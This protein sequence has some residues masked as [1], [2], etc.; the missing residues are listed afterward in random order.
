MVFASIRNIV[1]KCVDSPRCPGLREEQGLAVLLALIALS[2]FSL[3]SFFMVLGANTELHISDNRESQIQAHYAAMAGLVHTREVIRGLQYNDLLKGPDG[4]YT[5]TP[6]Y[7]SQARTFSFRNPVSWATARSLNIV[8]PSGDLSGLPDDGLL[9]TGKYNSTNGTPLIPLAGIAQTAPNPYGA[10]TVTTSRYFVRV[11]DNNGEA[12]ELAAD[13]S[14][15]P[16]VDG[17]GIIVVRSMGVAQTIRQVTAGVVRRN[18]VAV[19]E[20]RFRQSSTFRLSCPLVIEGNQVNASFNGN[21]FGI[22][23]GSAPGIGTIDTNTGDSNY[24]DQILKSAAGKKGSITGGGLPTPSVQDITAGVSS[25]PDT[26]QLMDPNYLWNFVNNVVPKFADTV[27][28]GNQKWAGGSAPYIG[29]YDETKPYNA[30]GQDPKVILVNGDLETSG[31]LVGGGL[32]VVT[33]SLKLNGRFEYHGLVLAIGGGNVDAGGLNRGIYGG[34]FVA[35]VTYS[36]GTASFGTPTFS[37]SGNSNIYTNSDALNMSVG[38]IPALQLS[39]REITS[40]LDP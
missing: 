17:D 27:Y 3:I 36:G 40:D 1:R 2:L 5:N 33:G 6:A 39:Y 16:F 8:N 35:N 28:N 20:S 25:D 11:A 19:V 13:A 29:T 9:S 12:S 34:M 37:M 4:T 23:G 32:L 10:G 18:S 31:N 26:A 21:A 38:L 30:P 22:S 24:P 7:L 15:N 14:N